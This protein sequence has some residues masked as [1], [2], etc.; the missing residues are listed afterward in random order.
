[1]KWIARLFVF[2]GALF[3]GTFAASLFW[4]QS[5]EDASV[6]TARSL[7]TESL[8]GT[9][10]GNWGHNDGECTLEIYRVDGNVFYGRLKKEGAEVLFEGK[11]NPKTRRLA[12]TETEV[13]RLGTHMTGW[14]LGENRG[15]ISRDGRIL[16][17]SGRDEW[18]QY[19][20]AASNY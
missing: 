4:G 20:W 11:F 7:T 12:F 19:G 1:M 17:G 16:V 3:L 8:L 18:G 15:I 6:N 5:W 2:V 14:S 10:Q 13:L 9:W